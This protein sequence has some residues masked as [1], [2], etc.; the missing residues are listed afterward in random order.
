MTYDELMKTIR[1]APFSK[2]MWSHTDEEGTF[3]L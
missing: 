1:S 2:E 3:T